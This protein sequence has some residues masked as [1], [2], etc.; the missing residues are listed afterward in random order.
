MPTSVDKTTSRDP[1]A[2]NRTP[3]ARPA[4]TPTV[5]VERLA[6]LVADGEVGWPDGLT[7]RQAADLTAAVCG[8]R[9]SRLISLVA[10][11]IAEDIA[12]NQSQGA[13]DDRHQV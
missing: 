12:R 8:L 6:A 2:G 1:D 13:C 11:L 7:Q 10:R 3:S 4:D 9:R 5:T